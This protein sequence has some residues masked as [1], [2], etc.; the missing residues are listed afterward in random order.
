[1][2]SVTAPYFTLLDLVH[3]WS[4]QSRNPPAMIL[5]ALCEW[6]VAGGFPEGS[7]VDSRGNTISTLDIYMSFRNAF[8]TNMFD[9]GITIGE[10]TVHAPSE[11]WGQPLLSRVLVRAEGMLAFCE[12]TSTL[13]PRSLL[14]GFQY[15]WATLKGDKSPAPPLC[16]DAEQYAAREFARSNAA[17][18]IANL[19]GI[20]RGLKEGKRRIGFQRVGDGPIDF[21]FWGDRWCK[22]AEA[23]RIELNKCGDAELLSRI[24]SVE[25]QWIAFRTAS[26]GNGSPQPAPSS[27]ADA[28]GPR[29]AAGRPVGSGAFTA[30]DAPL[31]EQMREDLLE[32]PSLSPTAAARRLVSR[33]AGGGSE[34]SKIK[35][36][37]QRYLQK[38]HTAP[39]PTA[40]D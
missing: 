6:A 40:S 13:P 34:E 12:R 11:R 36:L 21:E 20:L 33:A 7:F 39:V 22:L 27:V 14:S 3:G 16:P 23:A 35:R 26:L 38:Y 18:V 30:L 28:T 24:Q 25:A 9:T 31:V 10:M 8:K 19:E 15:F 4:E 17:S 29:R 1:M 2:Q 32:N 5:R 37:T